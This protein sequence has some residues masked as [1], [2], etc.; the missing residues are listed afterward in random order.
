MSGTSH[1]P[2]NPHVVRSTRALRQP[3][4][5]SCSIRSSPECNAGM[6]IAWIRSPGPTPTIRHPTTAP[7][8]AASSTNVRPACALGYGLLAEAAGGDREPATEASHILDRE[9]CVRSNSVQD[10]R[11]HIAPS[12]FGR[13]ATCLLETQSTHPRNA[14]C[15]AYSACH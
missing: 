8:Y 7:R 6:G 10:D 13:A 14:R 12:Y 1:S 11:Q 2:G 5:P 3:Y 4:R 15:A 9:L